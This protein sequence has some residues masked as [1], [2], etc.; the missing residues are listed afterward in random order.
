[1]HKCYLRLYLV[2]LLQ[3]FFH[4]A[5]AQD[6]NRGNTSID[7]AEL[8]YNVGRF[9]ECIIGLTQCLQ[10]KKAFNADQ[11]IQAFHILAK[12]YLAIDSIA[13]ADSVIQELLALKEDFEADAKDPDRFGNRVLFIRSTIISSVSKRNE[14]IRLAPATTAI[15]TAEEIKQRGYTDLIQVLQDI[16]GFDVSIYYGQLY[17]NVY[18]RGLRTNN[19]DKTLLLV[20]GVEENDL[21]TNFVDISQQYPLTNIKRIEVIYGPASTMYG[22]T[23]FSGVINIITKEPGDYLQNKESFGV[24]ASAGVATYDTRYLDLSAAYKKNGFSFSVTGKFYY[25]DRPK[26][27]DSLWDYDPDDY[28]NDIPNNKYK[29]IYTIPTNAKEYIIANNL[30]DP[31][32]YYDIRNDSDKL[33]L[34]ENGIAEILRRNKALV[35]QSVINFNYTDFVNPS[36]SY[37]INARMNFSD[38]S[39]GFVSWNKNEGIGT[40]YTDVVASVNASRWITG[41][42]Y[43]YLKYSKRI[44]DKLLFTAFA[45]YRIH[46]IKNGSKITTKK[47]Y[48]SLGG[49]TLKDLVDGVPASWVTTYYYEQSEQFRSEF[50]LLYTPIKNFYLNSGI[51]IRNS[52]LQGYYLTSTTSSTPQN[53]GTTPVTPGGNQYNV[54][55]IGVYSQGNYRTKFG[56][57]ITLGA[58]LDYNEVRSGGGLGYHLSPRFVVDYTKHNYIFKTIVSSGIENVSNFTKFDE[59]NIAPNP[60]LKPETIYNY[61]FSV[62]K[63]F[64]EIISADVDFFYSRIRDVVSAVIS[65]RVVQNQNIG[66]FKIKGIQSNIYFRSPNKKWQATLNYSFTDPHQTQSVDT[67]GHVTNIDLRVADIAKHKINGI[68]NIV[69]LKNFN[70]N[71]RA[72]Y[73]SSKKDSINTSSPNNKLRFDGYFLCNTAITADNLIKGVSIQLG[74]NNLFNKIYSSPGIR[75]S[76]GIRVPNEIFQMGRNFFLKL[77]YQL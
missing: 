55:D 41:H 17:A 65:N 54:N 5:F 60:N 31:S 69:V 12:C 38:F 16:P 76:G 67:F 34:N 50:K 53:D 28:E 27:T 9:D 52:Q 36:K 58:R 62:G 71:L 43:L 63:K 29:K 8:R 37:Y 14:D 59:I 21:W 39:L 45:N 42:D 22:P 46:A 1:M 25:S 61:E 64:S 19:T 24:N 40:T 70:I 30:P 48:T 72:N 68:V 75:T 74:C 2:L 32:P 35:N 13:K 18:Q 23:A 49:L 77:N 6:Y 4:G 20:D 57:G 26:L 10:T 47:D 73:L 51:E 56:L 11:K 44:T 33:T 3:C 66:E 15:I 7:S